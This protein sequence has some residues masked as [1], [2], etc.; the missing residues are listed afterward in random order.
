MTISRTF[1]SDQSST[2]SSVADIGLRKSSPRPPHGSGSL[3]SDSSSDTFGSI[4]STVQLHP[5]TSVNPQ[6]H[7]V[8]QSAMFKTS[9]EVIACD[10]SGGSYSSESHNIQLRIPEGAIS[11]ASLAVSTNLEFA[12]TLQ[13]PFEFP[14]DVK[15]VSPIVW[16]STQVGIQFAKS[17][18][19]TLPHFA[20]RSEP[21]A[22]YAADTRKLR[23]KFQFQR[24]RAREKGI[25]ERDGT[26]KTKL[27]ANQS[28]F[29]CIACMGSKPIKEVINRAKYY[30]V[31][32][33]PKTIDTSQW[34][35]FYCIVLSL[36]T[37]I[38]VCLNTLLI[39][40]ILS[41]LITRVQPVSQ[42]R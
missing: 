40:F 8:L 20:N 21:L 15:P 2:S 41:H 13:G 16:F 29:V 12:A 22:F 9:V 10:D 11:A 1:R 26:L 38:E 33:A 19:L 3:D 17:V 39:I 42:S 4:G 31:K 36:P 14:A 27:S 32:A 18:E 23:G 6:K 24:L 25:T 30:I 34:K 7:R 28:R 37:C 35:V 5:H